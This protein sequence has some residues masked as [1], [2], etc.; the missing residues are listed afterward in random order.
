M[1]NRYLTHLRHRVEDA[2]TTGR[3]TPLRKSCLLELIRRGELTLADACRKYD[4]SA[5]EIASWQ[6][7]SQRY[8]ARGLAVT[9]LQDLRT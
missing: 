5:E 2:Q 6:A 4:L 7:R 1:D 3:W 8:G 9:K